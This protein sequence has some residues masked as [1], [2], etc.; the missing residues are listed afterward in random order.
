MGEVYTILSCE[1]EMGISMLTE[2]SISLR[3]SSVTE[4]GANVQEVTEG[5]ERI[6][7][8]RLSCICP[9]YKCQI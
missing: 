3:S 8:Q 1:C 9:I 5:I 7:I 4:S 6:Y 2:A